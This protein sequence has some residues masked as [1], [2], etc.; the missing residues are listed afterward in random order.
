MYAC[1]RVAHRRLFVFD[2]HELPVSRDDN[3]F[4]THIMCILVWNIILEVKI[5]IIIITVMVSRYLR[6]INKSNYNIFLVQCYCVR[7]II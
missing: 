6:K 1:T 4:F 3:R 7:H 5:Q 2:Q